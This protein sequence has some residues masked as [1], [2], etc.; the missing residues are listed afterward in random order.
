[1]DG[2]LTIEATVKRAR[3]SMNETNIDMNEGDD[4]SGHKNQSSDCKHLKTVVHLPLELDT[5]FCF[6]SNLKCRICQC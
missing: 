2:T 1:M 5:L 3:P 6:D 4:D